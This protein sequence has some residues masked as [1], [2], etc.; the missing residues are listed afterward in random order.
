MKITKKTRNKISLE[1]S[2]TIRI[3]YQQNN[4][5]GKKLVDMFPQYSR[6]QIY[7]HAKKPLNTTTIDKRRHNKGRPKKLTAYDNR[8]L[9][10]SLAS[11]RESDGSFT[12]NRIQLNAG[13]THVS[14]RTVRRVLNNEGYY[15]LRSR[16]KGRLRPKD[17]KKRL[18][19]C[20]GQLKEKHFSQ[21]WTE[22]INFYLDGKGFQYKTN[23]YDQAR[24]PS[25]R[26][27]RRCNEGLDINCVAKGSKEGS[28][29]ATFMVAIGHGRG[30]VM[31]KQYFGP[32][33]GI[34]FADIVKS[35]FPRIFRESMNPSKVFLMDGCPRQNSTVTR[36][37]WERVGAK[38]FSIPAK[39]PDLNPIENF[40]NLVGKQLRKESIDKAITKETFDEF[41][42]R[43]KK[44]MLDFK[45][46]E[47]DK[48]IETMEKRLGMVVARKGQRI[49][50]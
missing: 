42:N 47:I 3:L 40:F 5:R 41:S 13:L 34:T 17:L 31:C 12:S 7:V 30:V 37:E 48:I 29:N 15:Y 2:C 28:R 9:L 44:C 32:I 49:K 50:Y 38:L 1:H 21:F 18:S 27:W 33:T 24:A 22:E 25:S 39:S 46:S 11:L 19:F 35:E 45:S 8:R 20:K 10:C 6:A 43:I 14:N 4:V 36:T 23:P 16:K 26:E